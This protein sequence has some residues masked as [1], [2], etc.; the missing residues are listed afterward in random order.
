MWEVNGEWCMR[1]G[2]E[3]KEGRGRDPNLQALSLENHQDDLRLPYHFKT[4]ANGTE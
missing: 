1:G 4:N 2:R 3:R